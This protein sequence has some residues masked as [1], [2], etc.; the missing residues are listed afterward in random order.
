MKIRES[1]P[2][3]REA[4]EK[5]YSAAFPDEPLWP[6]VTVLL[7]CDGVRSLMAKQSGSVLGHC[8]FTPCTVAGY[9]APVAL[10]GPLAVMPNRQRR[11]IGGRLV[12]AGI[13]QLAEA[14]FT[15]LFV[16]GD[17]AYYGRFGFQPDDSVTPPYVLPEAW[18]EAWRSLPLRQDVPPIA[19]TLSV[20]TPWQDVALWRE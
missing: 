16:L 2:E 9:E 6:L 5:L 19:G 3:D 10:L 17:P 1:V 4:L 15:H 11:G 14:G 7:E 18:T 20:P 8:F 12:E 13:K